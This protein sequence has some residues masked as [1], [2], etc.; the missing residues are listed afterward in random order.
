MT[1][2]NLNLDKDYCFVSDALRSSP[3]PYKGFIIDVVQYKN[4]TFA[5]RIYRANIEEFSEGQ[6]LSLFEWLKGRLEVVSLLG[7]GIKIGLQIE[8]E[9]PA[10]G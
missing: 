8:E 9:V 7:G 1:S 2:K 4:R 10:H 5:Y 6:K 3:A